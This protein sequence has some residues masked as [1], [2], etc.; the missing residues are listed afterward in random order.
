MPPCL[1]GR[2]ESGVGRLGLELCVGLGCRFAVCLPGRSRHAEVLIVSKLENDLPSLLNNFDGKAL[3][4]LNTDLAQVAASYDCIT[5]FAIGL[6]VVGERT[7]TAAPAMSAG[8]FFPNSARGYEA[9]GKAKG[10][11]EGLDIDLNAGF[12]AFIGHFGEVASANSEILFGKTT[13]GA[14]VLNQLFTTEFARHDAGVF[15]DLSKV[16]DNRAQC[17]QL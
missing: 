1:D 14:N 17:Q 6:D 8:L 11:V 12:A 5:R 4:R 10:L 2:P 7:A 13:V 15:S 3:T 16:R 9:R